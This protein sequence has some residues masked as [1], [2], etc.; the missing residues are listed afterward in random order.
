MTQVRLVTSTGT[1]SL[2][3]SINREIRELFGSGRTNKIFDVKICGDRED[4][5]ALIIY[6]DLK[7]YI[8]TD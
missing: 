5:V 6:D 4:R 8:A 1:K 7:Q 3:G 2:E